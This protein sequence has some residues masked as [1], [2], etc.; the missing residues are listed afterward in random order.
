MNSETQCQICSQLIC[1]PITLPCCF[2]SVCLECI[3]QISSKEKRNS[4]RFIYKCSLCSKDNQSVDPKKVNIFLSR[5]LEH[6]SQKGC[7][8]DVNCEDCGNKKNF[9]ETFAC[10]ECNKKVLCKDCHSALHSTSMGINKHHKPVNHG[11]IVKSF[12]GS[13]DK[14]ILCQDHP[15]QKN[16]AYLLERPLPSL[17]NLCTRA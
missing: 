13:L 15:N 8:E 7:F 4:D 11:L 17:F 9:V 3:K 1:S 6:C 2:A 12:V 16:W 10:N 5:Y 14:P